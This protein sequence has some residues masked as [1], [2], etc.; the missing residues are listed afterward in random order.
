MNRQSIIHALNALQHVNDI[1]LAETINDGDRDLTADESDLI[2][3]V[4]VAIER[5]TVMLMMCV[6]GH[7][8]SS[9]TFDPIDSL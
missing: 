8:S 6:R 9:A 7:D 5:G 4:D 3:A 1:V 2:T